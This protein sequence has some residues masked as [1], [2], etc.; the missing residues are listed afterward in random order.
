MNKKATVDFESSFQSWKKRTR[1]SSGEDYV[2][3]DLGS[4]SVDAL[5]VKVNPAGDVSVLDYASAPTA[6]YLDGAVVEAA[7]FVPVLQ[8]VIKDVTKESRSKIRKLNVTFTAPYVSYITHFTSVNL[9]PRKKV[10]LS[11]VN[12]AT[13]AAR[14][15]ISSL[16]EHVIQ[17][18]PVRYTLDSI[19]S[20][21]EPPLGM[22]GRQLGMELLFVTAPEASLEQMSRAFNEAGY[23][24][25]EWCTA[26]SVLPSQFSVLPP[27][28]E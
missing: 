16:L 3:V 18:V 7:L 19:Y 23:E 11:L 25:G 24:V 15:E 12:E 13:N 20:G 5:R 4:A 14:A 26:V 28:P 27:N 22:G 6:G 1:K 10:T 21:G 17:V 2:V 9:P 8:K